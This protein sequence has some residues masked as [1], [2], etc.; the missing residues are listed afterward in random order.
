MHPKETADQAP[1]DSANIQQQHTDTNMP[2]VEPMPE[3]QRPSDV[4]G[5]EIIVSTN[6][7]S[8]VTEPAKKKHNSV[9]PTTPPAKPKEPAPK[10]SLSKSD[11]GSAD[12]L[13][14]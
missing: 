7:D 5:D 3:R 1:A 14:C 9:S 8:D 10:T 11:S 4:V 6:D 13:K 2:A 12:E